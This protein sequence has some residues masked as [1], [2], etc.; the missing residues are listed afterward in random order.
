MKRFNQN[1]IPASDQSGESNIRPS[2][3]N[4]P[5]QRHYTRAGTAIF[6]IIILHFVSQFIF[7][8]G[9]KIAPEIEAIKRQSVEIQP[10]QPQNEQ[11]AQIEI[12]SAAKKP[13]AITGRR[14]AIPAAVTQP[15][16]AAAIAPARAVT[17]KKEPRGESRAERLRRAERLL[18]GV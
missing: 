17:K 10:Q 1:S 12:E 4:K 9:E 14:K 2:L 18:T 15:K 6:A 7:F 11:I 8:Q 3:L 13:E 5:A 16:P